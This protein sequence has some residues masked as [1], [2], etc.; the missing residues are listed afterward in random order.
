MASAEEGPAA[1][2]SRRPSRPSPPQARRPA[3]PPPSPPHCP[4]VSFASAARRSAL[5]SPSPPQRGAPP[6]RL[7]RLRSEA[8]R[9]AVSGAARTA[10]PGLVLVVVVV[11][12]LRFRVPA[13]AKSA[14]SPR[15][16]PPGSGSAMTRTMPLRCRGRC[17]VV[18]ANPAD[19]ESVAA[20]CE[21]VTLRIVIAI[22]A[23]W[24]FK[25]RRR[26]LSSAVAVSSDV[27]AG[28]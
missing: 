4:A 26:L 22:P 23:L 16:L 25:A 19:C 28:Q 3:L 2:R 27:S 17:G 18:L 14:G 12:A 6:C 15:P 24:P 13:A 5:P 7:L 20:G 21:S 1:P 11:V 9:P 10:S 8:L